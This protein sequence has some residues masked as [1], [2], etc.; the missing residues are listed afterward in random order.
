[1]NYYVLP[2]QFTVAISCDEHEVDTVFSQSVSLDSFPKQ[3]TLVRPVPEVSVPPRP[4]IAPTI[5]TLLNYKHTQ[6][7]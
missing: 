4:P 5:N 7:Y 2:W 3:L 6:N 1:M